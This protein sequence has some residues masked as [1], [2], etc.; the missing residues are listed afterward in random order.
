MVEQITAAK[1]LAYE[2]TQRVEHSIEHLQ[3]IGVSSD[4]GLLSL[5]SI[6]EFLSPDFLT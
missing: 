4:A 2:F 6:V 1:Q 5:S 3:H